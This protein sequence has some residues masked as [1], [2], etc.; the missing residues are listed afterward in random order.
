MAL[1][2]YREYARHRGVALRAVQKAIEARRITAVF[3]DGKTKIDSDQADRDWTTHTDP[4]ARSP[5]FS[6]G[7]SVPPAAPAG[8]DDDEVDDG[9]AEYREVRTDAAKI[10]RD[11][12]RLELQRDLGEVVSRAEVAR[13]R[14]TEF[15]ALRDAL[16]NLAP[17]LAPLV[18]VESDP[19]RCEQLYLDALADVLTT[20]ADQVLVRDV[21]QDVD[22]DDD[23]A[24]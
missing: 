12:E 14:F 2:G 8:A 24:D 3:V 20:F 11:R 4:V 13:L 16:G 18:A 19:I 15:R 9:T 6:A 5:L 7:P 17:R 21:L 22:D 1:M 23:A 10:K